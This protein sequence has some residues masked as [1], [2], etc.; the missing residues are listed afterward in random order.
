MKKKLLALIGIVVV[1]LSV[2][3]FA[4][5]SKDSISDKAASIKLPS[6]TLED[7]VSMTTHQIP[8]PVF[9]D[10]IYTLVIPS[11]IG[12]LTY[13]N[14]NDIRWGSVIYGGSD[15]IAS[16]GC[17]PTVLS[18]LVSSFTNQA[19]SPDQMAH[20]AREHHYWISGSGSMHAL[21]PEG[22]K[23]FGLS[24]EPFT[25]YTEEGIIQA[26]KS[27]SIFV[28][29]MGPGH[30]TSTGHFI[31]IAN[32]WSGSTVR[33]ADSNDINNS[34]IPWEIK[35]ILSEL[36]FDAKAGGPLWKINIK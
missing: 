15:S 27:G 9:E 34:Q 17:G 12:L 10:G 4:I 1:A 33:I 21:I 6:T 7:A 26:L 18:M 11:S 2:Y 13:Y 8:T 16:Y 24:A 29:L 20:W 5:S 31:I 25:D 3:Y 32:Y 22:C 35:D 23:Y 28:A 30:L 36:D 14:Q 19:I